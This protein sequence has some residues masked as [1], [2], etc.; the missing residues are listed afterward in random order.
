[1]KLQTIKQ[2]LGTMTKN[3]WHKLPWYCLPP[4]FL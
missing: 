1:M 4:K 3:V 2:L